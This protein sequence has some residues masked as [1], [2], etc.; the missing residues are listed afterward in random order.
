MNG[1]LCLREFY[2]EEVYRFEQLSCPA[3]HTVKPDI[4]DM[5]TLIG[6]DS[7]VF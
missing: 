4:Y 7:F 6:V 1:E 3:Y 5:D 2:G